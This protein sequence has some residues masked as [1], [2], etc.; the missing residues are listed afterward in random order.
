ME[1]QTEMRVLSAL[2]KVTK[3]NFVSFNWDDDISNQVQFDSVQLIELFAALEMEFGMELPLSL[4]NA[5]T[6][7][8]FISILQKQMVDQVA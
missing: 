4:M 3:Q 2:N 8:D 7:R 1:N 5:R 6:G